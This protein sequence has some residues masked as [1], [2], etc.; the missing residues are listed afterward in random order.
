MNI[1]N[2]L[3]NGIGEF[4][5]SRF[6]AVF[7]STTH[8]DED[9]QVCL[10]PEDNSKSFTCHQELKKVTQE[11][12]QPAPVCGIQGIFRGDPV[13]AYVMKNGKAQ[14][15]RG[16]LVEPGYQGMALV[17]TD[18]YKFYAVTFGENISCPIRKIPGTRENLSISSQTYHRV[19]TTGEFIRL[20]FKKGDYLWGI[21]HGEKETFGKM[22]YLSTDF[23]GNLIVGLKTNEGRIKQCPL[24][25]VRRVEN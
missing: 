4:L 16:I 23:E 2:E 21:P 14:K 24:V 11:P 13:E 9:L 18:E 17:R 25:T 5:E 19:Q 8:Y 15:V 6:D 7:S 3:I 10:P 20:D 1:I 22:E 12:E